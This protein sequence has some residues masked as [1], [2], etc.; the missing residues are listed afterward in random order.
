M[1]TQVP[2]NLLE[3]SQTGY[4]RLERDGTRWRVARRGGALEALIGGL[5]HAALGS[6]AETLAP[7]EERRALFKLLEES[8]S[9][10]EG[11]TRPLRLKHAAGHVLWCILTAVRSEEMAGASEVLI[12]PLMSFSVAQ[13]GMKSV[14]L[15]DKDFFQ[16]LVETVNDGLL[17]NAPDGS[18]LFMN[19]RLAEMLGYEVGELLGRPILSLMDEE[20]QQATRSR[21]AKRKGG[22]EEVF[23]CRWMHR[24]GRPVWTQASA[25]PLI[26]ANG[27]HL[28]SVVALADITLRK[29]AESALQRLTEEL[30]QRVEARTRELE[31]EVAVRRTAEK[32]A[33]A[34]L[35]AKSVFLANMSHELRTPLN[36]II[37]YVELWK[38][39]LEESE[40]EWLGE[41]LLADLGRIHGAASHL[42]ELISG[43]LDLSRVEAGRV[44]I[45][46]REV[47]VSELVAQVASSV[48]GLA[49]KGGNRLV[50]EVAPGLPLL[51]TDM[52]KLR[53]I[54]LN[55]LTNASKFTR[56]GEIKLAVSHDVEGGEVVFVVA[57]TGEGI[58]QEALGRIFEPFM[59]E[60]SSST[61][62]V[63]GAGL[64]LAISRQFAELLGGSLTLDSVKHQGTRFELRL[65][66]VAPDARGG[67]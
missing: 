2:D 34:A 11:V 17:V 22:R 5:P 33:L 49:A 55:G 41:Q 19:Q 46:V 14:L 35:R 57:D 25:K 9:S 4:L 44:A 36:A 7:E 60:D 64:G 21:L 59:Q 61:R 65:P 54:L 58:S 63:D 12:R 30:E 28:G 52:T 39:E 56:D 50:V 3:S 20:E 23:D 15:E 66:L 26:D 67:L 51:R 24:T 6:E 43:V 62:R 48:E 8:A 32:A 42:L 31:H 27:H 40:G 38:E 1:S 45:E 29:E 37:G 53:Q 47:A 10:A 16:R 13:T 18:I